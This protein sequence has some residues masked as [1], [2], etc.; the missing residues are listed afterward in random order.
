MEI[1]NLSIA[2][3][4]PWL[5]V[6]SPGGSETLTD[7]RVGSRTA[8]GAQTPDATSS[9]ARVGDDGSGNVVCVDLIVNGE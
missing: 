5:E 9:G 7:D 1:G 4:G 8:N 2:A 6:G 3:R